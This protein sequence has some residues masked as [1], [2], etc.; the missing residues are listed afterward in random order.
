M[1]IFLREGTLLTFAAN[2]SLLLDNPEHIWLVL[3][4]TVRVYGVPLA[5]GAPSGKRIHLFDAGTGQALFGAKPEKDGNLGLMACGDFNARV[6]RLEKSKVDHLTPW[7]ENW[8]TSLSAGI[9]RDVPP[10]HYEILQGGQEAAIWQDCFLRTR[11]KVLWVKSKGALQFLGLPELPGI[12]R[13]V[14]FPLAAVAWIFSPGNNTLEVLSTHDF[15]KE[16]SPWQ[17]LAVFHRVVFQVIRRHMNRLELE[18]RRRYISKRVRDRE[19]VD[20]AIAQLTSAVQPERELPQDDDSDDPLLWACRKIGD[21]MGIK[22]V[23]PPVRAEKSRDPLGDLAKASHFRVRKVILKRNWWKQDNGPFLAYMEED[24]R[25]VALIPVKDSNYVLYDPLEGG[26]QLLTNAMVRSLKPFG[27]VFYRP[28]PSH[29]LTI[30]DLLAYVLSGRSKRD[31]VMLFLMGLAGGILGLVSPVANGLLFDTIIPEAQRS[32]LLVMAAFLL[33][34]AVAGASFQICQYVAMQRLEGKAGSALQSAVWDRLLNLPVS[35]FRN[36]TAGD[37]TQRANGINTILG[38]LSGASLGSI[39][40]GIFSFVNL[41]LLFYYSGR[42]ALVAVGLVVLFLI[43]FIALSYWEIRYTRRLAELEGQI[44]GLVSQIIG[45]MAKF[46]VAGAENRAFYLW[47][48]AFAAQKKVSYQARQVSNYLLSFNAFY[49]VLT[50]MTLFAII[51]LAR[52][53]FMS[54]GRFLAFNAAFSGFLGAMTGLTATVMEVMKVVPQ[55]ERS[56]PILKALPE[57]DEV[58]GDPGD[59]T[60]EIEASQLYF[61]YRKDDPLVLKNVSFHI[62]P[63]EFVAF[64]GPSGSGKSTLLRLLLGF[65][66]PESGAVYFDGQDL[67]GLN[68]QAVRRQ[69]GVVLQNSQLRPGTI[70]DNITG[71]LPL[72][73]EDAWEAAAMAGLDQDI[74]QFPMGMHTVISMGSA[75]LSGGQRQRILIARAIVGKPG[76][77]LFDEATSALDNRTQAVVSESLEKLNATRVVIAHRLS[78]IINADRIYV[79]EQGKIVES[80]TYSELIN[81]EGLFAQLAKRQLA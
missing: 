78:T 35:F 12:E 46:R 32:Q 62:R 42:L 70:F 19:F 36:Y 57:V 30:W 39:F 41:A 7:L 72:T 71:S 47:S 21:S 18:E 14:F 22:I 44:S 67:A 51:G 31:L 54:T 29:A 5:G 10:K 61:R 3:E 50:S 79:L 66:T 8:I 75:T 15:I 9:C 43:I 55:Y 69:M 33:A 34:S 6:L 40:A 17:S 73:R 25:P 63:G 20:K 64:V 56:Q 49:P 26:K 76:I 13:D 74:Q 68:I 2:P 28:L 37:L 38:T 53:E 80:G 52:E 59:L 81:K 24:D 77:I 65:E 58:K 45:G 60:G 11:E 16:Y 4:G 23:P 48:R 27:Y 1:E